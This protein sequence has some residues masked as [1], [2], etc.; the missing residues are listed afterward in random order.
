MTAPPS[1]IVSLS[2]IRIGSVLKPKICIGFA[3]DPARIISGIDG[4]AVAS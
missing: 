1:H 4:T 2:A 3:G